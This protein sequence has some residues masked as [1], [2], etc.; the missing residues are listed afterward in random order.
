MKRSLMKVPC[1]NVVVLGMLI[2]GGISNAFAGGG[3]TGNGGDPVEQQFVRA[4]RD[5][6]G[7][8]ISNASIFPTVE[9]AVFQAALD[10]GVRVIAT[11]DKLE[12]MHGNPKSLLNFPKEKKILINRSAWVNIGE[13]EKSKCALAFH[14]YLGIFGL[15]QDNYSLSS[16]LL[17]LIDDQKI[18]G[19]SS[20][21]LPGEAHLAQILLLLGDKYG[22]R[23]ERLPSSS[24]VCLTLMD[25][26]TMG[27]G[28]Q[29][30]HYVE[31]IDC[32]TPAM[33]ISDLDSGFRIRAKIK[34]ITANTDSPVP[35]TPT[36]IRSVKVK[37]YGKFR[38][39]KVLSRKDRS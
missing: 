29:S 6:L 23:C 32:K 10:G 18:S 31:T 14:E 35:F 39:T 12:D 38:K 21:T 26:L 8:V 34:G 27:S 25:I 33:N 7:V 30:C 11:D 15:E 24:V 13:D 17:M 4:G 20:Q 22:A 28:P 5:A 37:G 1:F 36:E 2:L 16:R 19:G 9:V 3:E